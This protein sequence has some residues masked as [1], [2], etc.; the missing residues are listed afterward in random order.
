MH[1][2]PFS[3]SFSSDEKYDIITALEVIE[4]IEDL[5]DFFSAIN[6][7]LNDQGI[8]IGYFPSADDTAFQHN[9]NY[10]WLH[11]SF[12]HLVYPTEKGMLQLLR[13]IFGENIF[14]TTFFTRQGPDVIPNTIIIVIKGQEKQVTNKNIIELFRQLSYINDRQSFF[15]NMGSGAGALTSAWES[16]IASIDHTSNIAYLAG[17]LCAKFGN[18]EAALLFLTEQNQTSDI[19]E[20]ACLDHYDID[21]LVI[22][23]HCGSIDWLREQLAHASPNTK[24]SLILRDC[25]NVVERYDSSQSQM[26]SDQQN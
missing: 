21:C 5:P 8:F 11:S 13:P 7:S 22:A 12:E 9:A 25:A 24:L 6:N 14:M 15:A 18:T 19:N 10:H 26:A 4:H 17:L 23:M 2:G 3:S 1:K 20:V 16:G